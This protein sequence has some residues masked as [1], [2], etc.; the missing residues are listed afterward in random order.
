MFPNS[1]A[2]VVTDYWDPCEW[3]KGNSNDI[4]IIDEAEE[5]IENYLLGLQG[6]YFNGLIAPFEKR[7]FCFTATLTDYWKLCFR[8]AFQLPEDVIQHFHT[9]KFYKDG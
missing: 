5:V 9:A 8:M 2:V 4:F 3:V 6:T 1:H 7:V